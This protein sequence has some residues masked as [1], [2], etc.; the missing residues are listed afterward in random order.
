MGEGKRNNRK[1]RIKE[2]RTSFF[3]KM[4]ERFRLGFG[5]PRVPLDIWSFILKYGP[6]ALCFCLG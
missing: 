3:E 1:R 2:Y 6:F 5:M 4:S